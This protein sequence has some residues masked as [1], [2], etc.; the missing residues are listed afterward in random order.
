MQKILK[1]LMGP[2]ERAQLEV[3]RFEENVRSG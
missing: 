3:E 2:A 1:N